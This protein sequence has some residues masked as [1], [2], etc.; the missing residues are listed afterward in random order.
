MRG[1]PAGTFTSVA[2]CVSQ[3]RQRA[4]SVLAH[5]APHIH[6]VGRTHARV[7]RALEERAVSLGAQV[8]SAAR[9]LVQAGLFDRRAVLAGRARARAAGR[10]AEG[11]ERNAGA[12]AEAVAL[13]PTLE[14]VAI[15]LA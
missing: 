15:L 9:T 6:A 10:L 7:Q 13:L 14:L 4:A 3:Q 1:L 2:S 5:L 8:P 12:A 11:F